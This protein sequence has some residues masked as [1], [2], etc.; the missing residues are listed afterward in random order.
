MVSLEELGLTTSSKPNE[1]R[2]KNLMRFSQF[3]VN[4]ALKD[5]FEIK[6]QKNLE[7]DC[8]QL[9]LCNHK[10]Y[11]DPILTQIAIALASGNDKPIPAPAY[12]AYVK[13]RALGPLMISLFSYPIYGKDDGYTQKEKSLQYSVECFLKQDR[14]LIFPEGRISHDGKLARGKLGSAE[15]AWRAYHSIQADKYL[16]RKKKGMKMIPMDISYYPIAGIPWKDID[17]TTIRFGKSIDVDEELIDPYYAARNRFRNKAKLKMKLQIKLMNKVR[18]EIGSL[19]TINMD[20]IASRVVYDFIIGKD[21]Y[22][23]KKAHLEEKVLDIIKMLNESKKFYLSDHLKGEEKVKD[24]YADFIERFGK[25]GIIDENEFYDDLF[26]FDADYIF[27]EPEFIKDVRNENVILYNHNLLE[28]LKD[29]KKL[30]RRELR[31][32]SKYKYSIF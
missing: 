21:I 3:M 20:Q 26:N 13:H 18:K 8:Y 31:K 4:H 22:L 7:E 9:F 23:V 1:K 25:K 10:F 28:H 32:K 27:S 29:F 15:I 14:I 17:K 12:K 16:R 2:Y 6:G 30:E 11:T 5:A 19:T 24:A